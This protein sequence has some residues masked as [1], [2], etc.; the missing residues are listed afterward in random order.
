M[1]ASPETP[2]AVLPPGPAGRGAALLGRL[3]RDGG[4]GLCAKVAGAGLA[5]LMLVV[6]A[7]RMSIEA[8][9]TFGI[10]FSLATAL[11]QVAALGQPLLVLREVPRLADAGRGAVH[12][13]LVRRAYRRVALGVLALA[14]PAAALAALGFGWSAAAALGVAVLAAGFAVADLQSHLLRAEGQMLAALLPRDVIWR[15]G[16][17]A[18]T[19]LALPTGGALSAEVVL[20]ALGA[21]LAVVLALQAAGTPLRRVL[22]PPPR[23]GARPGA[24]LGQGA[25][26]LWLASVLPVLGPGLSVVLIGA[27]L[28][29]AAAAPF[30]A[31]LKTAQLLN[32]VLLAGNLASA[33]LVS[34]AHGRGEPASLQRLGATT[35][36]GAALLSALA[37]PVFAVF[38]A[39]ILELFG[40]GFGQAKLLLLVLAAGFVAKAALGPGA[41]MLQMTG[42]ER[43]AARI[44]ALANAFGLVLLVPATLACGAAGAAGAVAVGMTGGALWSA[45][46]LRRALGVDP[47]ILGLCRGR[48]G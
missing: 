48:G 26:W 20:L 47:T 10:A 39:P 36:G 44:M 46:A 2:A 35:A 1:P 8:F 33:P 4:F 15:A 40:D 12:H 31:A 21:A 13:A 11:A 43:T 24:S 42:C 34:R 28:G 32:L 37:L 17:V 29:P 7:R 38:G 23:A 27:L 45:M 14:A 9:G 41:T 5:Y 22:A 6:L 25:G 19:V 30:F 18:A 16:V 3:A